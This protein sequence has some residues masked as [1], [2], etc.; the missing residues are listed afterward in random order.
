MGPDVPVALAGQK[1]TRV[2]RRTEKKPN[3]GLGPDRPAAPFASGDARTA[4]P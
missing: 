4:D 1:F 2:H 3:S